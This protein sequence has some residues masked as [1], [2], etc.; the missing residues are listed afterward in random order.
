MS[1]NPSEML[2]ILFAIKQEVVLRDLKRAEEDIEAFNRELASFQAIPFEAA[3][4]E[5]E[6]RRA[7]LFMIHAHELASRDAMAPE[8]QTFY[9]ALGAGR[10]ADDATSVA[11]NK[12]TLGELNDHINAIRRREGLG[13]DEFWHAKDGP[14]DYR[15][16]SE[17]FDQQLTAIYETIVSFVLRRYHLDAQAD[18][19]E[20]DRVKFEIQREIGRRVLV[21]PGAETIQAE[22]QMDIYFREKFGD[23]AHERMLARVIEIRENLAKR[24]KSG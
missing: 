14:E 15:E 7:H 6:A 19:Y 1:E 20:K 21:P 13:E 11:A 8:V 12:D 4:P 5:I 3:T 17:E 9:A 22:E 18:L 16:A 2:A 23:E 24:S 10:I